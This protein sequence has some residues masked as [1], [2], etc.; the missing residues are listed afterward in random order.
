MMNPNV[1]NVT[2]Q[3]RDLIGKG[4]LVAD[5]S[6]TMERSQNKCENSRITQKRTPKDV[7]PTLKLIRNWCDHWQMMDNNYNHQNMDRSLV[8]DDFKGRLKD[9]GGAKWSK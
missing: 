8:R 5:Q 1:N 4:N 3:D 6:E 7:R 9:T 2:S